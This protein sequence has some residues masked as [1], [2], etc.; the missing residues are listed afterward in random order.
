MRPFRHARRAEASDCWPQGSDL[1]YNRRV[2]VPLVDELLAWALPVSV[3]PLFAD[4]PSGRESVRLSSS[5]IEELVCGK[6]LYGEDN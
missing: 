6:A 5:L 1:L 4:L 3:D 2:S